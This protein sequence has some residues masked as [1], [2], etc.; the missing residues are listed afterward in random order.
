M[1]QI[2]A[3]FGVIVS[4]TRARHHDLYIATLKFSLEQNKFSIKDEM[5]KRMKQKKYRD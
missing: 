4:Y 2:Q 3:Y 5:G 1:S